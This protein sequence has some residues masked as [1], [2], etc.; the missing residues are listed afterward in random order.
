MVDALLKHANRPTKLSEPHTKRAP[1]TAQSGANIDSKMLE[2]K[3]EIKILQEEVDRE[4]LSF[5]AEEAEVLRKEYVKLNRYD[6]KDNIH[7]LHPFV[8]KKYRLSR[9]KDQLQEMFSRNKEATKQYKKEISKRT[10]IIAGP[11]CERIICG[12]CK[13]VVE[14]FADLVNKSLYDP[15]IHF[16]EDVTTSLCKTREVQVNFYSTVNYYKQF[17]LLVRLFFNIA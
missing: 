13:V 7:D 15:Q 12:A 1:P 2:L 6:H 16:V 9:K 4:S 3:A 17:L 5:D 8:M 11:V 10:K 14:E